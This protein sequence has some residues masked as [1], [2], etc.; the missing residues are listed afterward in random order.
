MES[1]PGTKKTIKRGSS[2][3]ALF[4]FSTT[5]NQ[6]SVVEGVLGNKAAGRLWTAFFVGP[7]ADRV[8]VYSNIYGRVNS[9]EE[10]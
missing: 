10:Q 4:F 2:I 9:Y 8:I 6:K 5:E 1:N 7:E 3:G